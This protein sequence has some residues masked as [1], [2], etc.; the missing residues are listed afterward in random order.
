MDM[1]T[2]PTY[3]YGLDENAPVFIYLF[4]SKTV[5]QS[6]RINNPVQL[7]LNYLSGVPPQVGSVGSVLFVPH[8]V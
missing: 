3:I 5:E 8:S 7:F 1:P 4:L 6:A 2:R